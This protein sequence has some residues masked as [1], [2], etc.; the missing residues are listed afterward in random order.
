MIIP[1][2]SSLILYGAED[3]Y[4]A[5]DRYGDT[6]ST[7]IPYGSDYGTGVYSE[8]NSEHGRYTTPIEI[9]GYGAGESGT[10]YG[11]TAGTADRYST[12]TGIAAGRTGTRR[13]IRCTATAT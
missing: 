9:A 8:Y 1:F 7:T 11:Y 13:R 5:D 6:G 12:S 3:T 2:L 10:G 4:N